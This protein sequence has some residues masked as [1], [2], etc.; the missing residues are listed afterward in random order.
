MPSDDPSVIP[1]HVLR[2]IVPVIVN[3]ESKFEIYLTV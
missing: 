2:Q 1:N 3:P